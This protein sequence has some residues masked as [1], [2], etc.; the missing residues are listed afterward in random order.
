MISAIL[1]IAGILIGIIISV[2]LAS[3]QTE[4]G[5]HQSIS[6]ADPNDLLKLATRHTSDIKYYVEKSK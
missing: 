4:P 6:N 1:C 3:R 2:Y 5:N